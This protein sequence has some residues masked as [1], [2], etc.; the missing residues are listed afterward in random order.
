M[1]RLAVMATHPIQ[2]YGPWFAHLAKH[3]DLHAYY[4]HRQTPE[5]Q[6]AAGFS[7]AFE[8]DLPLLEGYES[9][10]LENVARRPGV[11][12][13]WGC[14]TPEIDYRLRRG[15]YDALLMFGWNK[16]TFLQGWR[17]AMRARMPVLVRLDNQLGS[18]RSLLKRAAKRPLYSLVL[19]HAAAY[20]SPG[21]R[22]DAYL[23]HYDVPDRRIHRLPHM[24][25]VERFAQGAYDARQSGAA[26]R[27]RKQHGVAADETVFLFVGKLIEKKRPILLLEALSRL[28]A[29][30]NVSIWMIGD[31]PLELEVD[32]RI[33]AGNLKVRRLGFVNQTQLPAYYAAANCLVLPSDA[34]ETWG[35]VVNEAQACGLPAIVSEEA[36]CAPELIEEDV[37]G[38]ILRRPDAEALAQLMHTAT[39]KADRL[40]RGPIQSKGQ[41]SS[42]DEGTRRLAEIVEHIA[43]SR[44]EAG[45][46]W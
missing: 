45:R 18:R 17:A 32:A 22:S 42:Y 28:G 14:N 4:A 19:P 9:T 37:T 8:W 46:A 5:G 25:D 12:S 3:M 36:G 31:G 34:D 43:E 30:A 13:F 2:Y 38:W 1:I 6:A 11:H 24:I 15:G 33:A 20:L 10:F 16:L 44:R 23:R 21:E 26:T 41:A 35:L 29:L 40:P 39:K 7:T 27:L